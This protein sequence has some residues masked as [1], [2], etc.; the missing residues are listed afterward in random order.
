MKKICTLFAM[1]F[2]VCTLLTACGG[3]TE[4][5]AAPVDL[6]AF[7]NDLAAQYSWTDESMMSLD[8]EMLALYYPGLE[9][10]SAEQLLAKA[11][12]MSYAVS[13]YV[14]M[15][16]SSAADAETAAG[17]LQTRIDTQAGGDAWYPETLEQWKAAKVI[18]HG[19]YTAMIA[20]GEHQAEIEEAWDALFAE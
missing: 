16:C 14:F 4:P 15:A 12:V 7:Y 11:P 5:A 2:A 3:G 17:I 8:D 10:I 6:T 20:S 18:T 1:T 19:A 9:E 13:E